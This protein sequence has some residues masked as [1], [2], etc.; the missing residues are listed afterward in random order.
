VRS[1]KLLGV[2]FFSETIT[3]VPYYGYRAKKYQIV[4]HIDGDP[5]NNSDDNLQ[6]VCQMCNCVKHAG[7]GCVLKG[8][9]ELYR[10]AWFSQN[11]DYPDA[12]PA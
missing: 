6:T 9:V 11:T 1:G 7:Q 10:I 8:I 4:D 2:A 12:I 5:E 3:S